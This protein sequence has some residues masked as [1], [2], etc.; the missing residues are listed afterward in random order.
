MDSGALQGAQVAHE[1]PYPDQIKTCRLNG[2]GELLAEA[3]GGMAEEQKGGL[4][5]ACRGGGAGAT[6][7]R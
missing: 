3:A 6:E 4:A 5:E 1:I 2:A 7:W